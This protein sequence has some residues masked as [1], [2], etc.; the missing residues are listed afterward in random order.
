MMSLAAV[1]FGGHPDHYLSVTASS[2]RADRLLLYCWSV[3]LIRQRPGK[4][5]SD[6]VLVRA[7]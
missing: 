5:E 6:A 2:R 3:V 4:R 1:G 7:A